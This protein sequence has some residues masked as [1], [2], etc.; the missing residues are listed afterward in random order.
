MATKTR[1]ANKTLWALEDIVARCQ[2]A[3]AA[4]RVCHE[5]AERRMEALLLAKLGTI[6][7]DLAVI[8]TTAREARAGRYEEQG[9]GGAGE[10]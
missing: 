9:S 5:V 4:W 3:R 1:V 2:S 6:S 10:R 7:D 8:E